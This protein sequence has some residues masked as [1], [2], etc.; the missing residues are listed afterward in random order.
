MLHIVKIF[1]NLLHTSLRG[2]IMKIVIMKSWG[3]LPNFT[4]LS[5]KKLTK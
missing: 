1:K 3:N 2:E 5:N 4:L